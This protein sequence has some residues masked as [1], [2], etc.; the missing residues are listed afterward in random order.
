MIFKL[1]TSKKTMQ[2]FQSI[3]NGTQLQPFILSK[4]SLAMSVK[5]EEALVKED[6]Q[7][8][9]MGIE[10]N[11]QTITNEF[12]T[13]FKCLIQMKEGRHIDDDEYFKVYVKAHLD[14]GA[15]LLEREYR[16]STD[17]LSH[18]L[19]LDSSL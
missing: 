12:D 9:N 6:F 5:C 7:T 11:R 17:F 13:I 15:K 18:L 16:Y 14:R 10:L 3:T 1:K 4:L 19:K 2:I 8:D